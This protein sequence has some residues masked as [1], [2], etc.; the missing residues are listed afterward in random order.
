MEEVEEEEMEEEAGD[1]EEEAKE[2]KIKETNDVGKEAHSAITPTSPPVQ[3]A[4][5]PAPTKIATD[6]IGADSAI[7]SALRS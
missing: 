7:A 2:E 3:E 6:I 4:E 5:T 1:E